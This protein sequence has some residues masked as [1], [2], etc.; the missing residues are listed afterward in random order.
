MLCPLQILY[1]LLLPAV[2][3]PLQHDM[4]MVLLYVYDTFL[5]FWSKTAKGVHLCCLF[6]NTSDFH[7][8]L[9]AA[10]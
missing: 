2:L 6:S 3:M 5:I 4:F 7:I 10:K 9:L 8:P 1:Y